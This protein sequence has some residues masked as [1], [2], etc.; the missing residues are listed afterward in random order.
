MNKNKH[1]LSRR[2]P[3]NIKR[4]VRR[5]DGFG[6]VICG[7]ALYDYEHFNPEFKD[8]EKHKAD[9]ITLLCPNHHRAKLA[10]TLT[11]DDYR[12]A[13]SQPY[14]I[15]H[16]WSSTEFSQGE[17]SPQFIIGPA[18]FNLGT[19]ICM[20][21]GE[22]IMGFSP[23]EEPGA[24]PRI[25]MKLRDETNQVVFEILNNEIKVNSSAYDIKS[26]GQTWAIRS[27]DGIIADLT[28]DL[29]YRIHISRLNLISGEWELRADKSSIS[30]LRN[31]EQ[32]WKIT[33]P[34]F[35]SGPCLIQC[36]S[37]TSKVLFKD[38]TF[39]GSGR[40]PV[41]VGSR[42]LQ[43]TGGVLVFRYPVY[44][45]VTGAR[46]TPIF[47]CKLA[48][49]VGLPRV[50]PVFSSKKLAEKANVHSSYRLESLGQKGFTRILKE[51][52]IPQGFT[53]I[54]FDADPTAKEQKLV[55]YKLQ[56]AIHLMERSTDEQIANT[57]ADLSDVPK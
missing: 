34:L 29:P 30:V 35:I 10:G 36:D 31:A 3:E 4:E 19:S 22:Q 46:Q 15:S 26:T 27:T 12:N 8:A 54:L 2:I 42:T 51:L 40:S 25:S 57:I 43:L 23:P 52:A 9:G 24:P 11:E 13:I 32:T 20:V 5:R 49:I 44:F 56:E 18:T 39:D 53:A 38:L 48:E 14:S 28:F 16:G 37:L 55:T 21:D 6:C 17:F 1:D 33:G 41:P 45:F 50:L 7:A 47:E